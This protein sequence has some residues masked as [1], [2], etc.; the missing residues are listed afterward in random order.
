M[1]TGA[2]F[3][4]TS[5][6]LTSTIVYWNR[7]SYGIKNYGVEVIFSGMNSVLNLVKVYRL[8]QTLLGGETNRQEGDLVSLEF[9]FRKGSGLKILDTSEML[10]LRIS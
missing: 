5:G 9:S 4:F 7:R 10:T 1:L 8:V 3:A 6:V 2:S